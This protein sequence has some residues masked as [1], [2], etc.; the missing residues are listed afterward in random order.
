MDFSKGKI[1]IS[2]T[3]LCMSRKKRQNERKNTASSSFISV[4]SSISFKRY[5]GTA[6]M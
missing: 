3:Y 5:C 1:T 2:V 4:P 6:R